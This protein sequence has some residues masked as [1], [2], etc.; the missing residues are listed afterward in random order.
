M[1]ATTA[2]EACECLAADGGISGSRFFHGTIK[3]TEKL[4]KMEL[5]H[6]TEL[7]TY[8]FTEDGLLVHRYGR[9]GRFLIY[10]DR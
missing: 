8:L 3:M 10:H 5:P 2:E 4:P 9:L 7:F 6:V 1:N